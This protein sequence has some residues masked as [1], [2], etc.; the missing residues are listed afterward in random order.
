MMIMKSTSLLKKKAWDRSS[1]RRTS[2]LR[3][4]S[5]IADFRSQSLR[6]EI[7]DLRSRSARLRPEGLPPRNE[8]FEKYT[9]KGR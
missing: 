6:F 7:C 2:S 1:C 8:T 3:E 5:Q 4:E 9:E